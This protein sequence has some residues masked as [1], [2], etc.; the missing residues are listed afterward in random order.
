MNKKS[1]MAYNG[2]ARAIG[3]A[4][5]ALSGRHAIAQQQPA[6]SPEPVEQVIVTGTRLISSGVNTPTPVTAVS[7]DLL[8]TMAP[9]TLV[10]SLIQLPVFDNNL[11]SQQAV[12]GSV[13][14]GR[15]GEDWSP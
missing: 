11:S 7:G 14:P 9:S 13:A 6:Q 1:T 10:E 12:G 4:C 8:Q 2:L 5:L 3:L 15:T